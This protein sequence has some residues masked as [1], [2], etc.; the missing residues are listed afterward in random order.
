MQID[1]Y[2]A[3]YSYSICH[4]AITVTLAV[5]PRKGH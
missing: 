1:F 5:E 2:G 4:P 3:Y